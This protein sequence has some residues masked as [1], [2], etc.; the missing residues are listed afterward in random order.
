MFSKL[1]VFKIHDD[2]SERSLAKGF[3]MTIC[4]TTGLRPKID[5]VLFLTYQ[6]QL[7]RLRRRPRQRKTSNL[8]IS[9]TKEM[10]HLAFVVMNISL[11]HFI[12]FQT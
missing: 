5:T 1:N 7:Y 3:K 12:N 2:K 11:I 8:S 10:T 6:H 9:T 4:Q